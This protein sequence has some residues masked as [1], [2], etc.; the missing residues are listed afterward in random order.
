[1]SMAPGWDSD[2]RQAGGSGIGSAA[3]GASRSARS[4]AL[5]HPA[6]WQAQTPDLV[7]P[8]DEGQVP[9]GL[10]R[11][12]LPRDQT[13]ARRTGDHRSE[14]PPPGCGCGRAGRMEL[15]RQAQWA[16]VALIT[17]GSWSEPRIS[18]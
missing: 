17:L 10:D 7:Q 9:P 3:N 8:G 18:C 4:K 2:P 5:Q 15:L 6:A 11:A 1:M 13:E 14:L 12:L 16:L